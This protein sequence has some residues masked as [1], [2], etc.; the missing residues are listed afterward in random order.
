MSHKLPGYSGGSAG[1]TCC[2]RGFR[3]TGPRGHGA[4]ARSAAMAP[5]DPGWAGCLFPLA[6][7]APGLGHGAAA[8]THRLF[9]CR[10]LLKT[11]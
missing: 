6:R 11:S 7:S 3:T 2:F 1:F 9:A 4:T 8:D 10:V 5:N